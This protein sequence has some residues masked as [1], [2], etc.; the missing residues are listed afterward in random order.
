MSWIPLLDKQV[1]QAGGRS[2]NVSTKMQNVRAGCEFSHS[3][4]AV[5]RNS[6]SSGFGSTI[7]CVPLLTSLD[8]FML[9]FLICKMGTIKVPKSQGCAEDEVRQCKQRT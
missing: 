5:Q 6:L 8:L 7:S 4:A 9:S 2:T 3:S 1:E